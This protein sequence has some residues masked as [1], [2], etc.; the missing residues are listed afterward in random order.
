MNTITAVTIAAGH[1]DALRVAMIGPRYTDA[2][3]AAENAED[4]DTVSALDDAQTALDEQYEQV[5]QQQV[6]TVAAKLGID[7]TIDPHHA[8]HGDEE[9]QVACEI[10]QAAHGRISVNEDTWTVQ[11]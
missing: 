6:H 8:S 5:W 10:A 11:A 1:D 9:F 2:Y 3:T 4:W 7:V